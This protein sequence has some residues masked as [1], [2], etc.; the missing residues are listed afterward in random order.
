MLIDV[1]FILEILGTNKGFNL[2]VLFD[3][4]Q[5]LDRPAFAGS[6]AF[7]NFKDTHPKTFSFLGKKEHVLVV[8]PHK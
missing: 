3:I 1:F 6:T 7:W 2:I 8:R 4:D 5:V